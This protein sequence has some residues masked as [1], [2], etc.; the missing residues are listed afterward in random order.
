M[1]CNLEENKQPKCHKYWPC[2]EAEDKKLKID[3][4]FEV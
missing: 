3:E 2:T 4:N 1:L